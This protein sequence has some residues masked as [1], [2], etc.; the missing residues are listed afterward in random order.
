MFSNIPKQQHQLGTKCSNTWAYQGHSREKPPK[1][2]GMGH[3]YETETLYSPSPQKMV[4][5]EVWRWTEQCRYNGM[6]SPAQLR[7]PV[8]LCLFWVLQGSLT[9]SGLLDCNGL[10][11]QRSWVLMSWSISFPRCRT[12]VQMLGELN[13]LSAN[14]ENWETHTQTRGIWSSL[15]LRHLQPLNPL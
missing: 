9:F 8:F 6:Y 10:G 3:R 13:K 14:A 12:S 7:R 1:E 4:L 11:Q 15:Y 2:G 5:A